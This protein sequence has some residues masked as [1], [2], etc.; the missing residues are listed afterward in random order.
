MLDGGYVYMEGVKVH[1]FYHNINGSQVTGQSPFE[2]WLNEAVTVHIQRQYENRLFG[3][4]YM[5]LEKVNYAF[6]PGR[7]P[8]AEDRKPNSMAIEPVGFNT[9]HELISAMTYSK[10]PE[11]V[12]MVQLILGDQ[13]FDRALHNYH[14]KFAFSNAKTED[15]INCMAE[16]APKNIDLHRMA[17][18]WLKRTGYPTVTVKAIDFDEKKQEV[19]VRIKQSGFENQES[20]NRYPWIVPLDFSLVKGGKAVHEGLHV[21]TKEEDEIVVGKVTSAPEFVSVGRNWSFFGEVNNEAFTPQMLEAQAM[22]DPDTV[23]RYLAFQSMVDEEKAVIIQAMLSGNG[24]SLKP[25]KR[26]LE[27]YNSVLTDS[28][29]SP[30][31]KA[32][33]LRVSESIS[34]RPDLQHRYKELSDTKKILLKAVYDAYGDTVLQMYDALA[35]KTKPG[36]QIEGLADRSLKGQLLKVLARGLPKEE[37]LKRLKAQLNSPFMTDKLVAFLLLLEL[38]EPQKSVMAEVKKEW[39]QHPIGCEQYI[40]AISNSDSANS[41]TYIRELLKEGFFNMSLAG[42]ARTVARGWASN[43]KLSLLTDAGLDLTVELIG[44]IGKVNQMSAYALLSAFGDLEK[45]EGAALERLVEALKKAQKILDKKEQQSLYNQLD[46]MLQKY[47]TIE[48]AHAKLPV[49]S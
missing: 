20:H 23:N 15:W 24:G 37:L 28:N 18:G 49:S 16:L 30:M 45:F 11:F 19:R 12:R 9:T 2:I 4:D 42:H 47:R 14:S 44:T 34:S 38:P 29:M 13:N 40:F 26:Y 33:I 27:L 6:T 17:E 7:G 10:A 22:S 32:F 43:R 5:R 48:E 21:L 39:M 31:N 25:S 3:A 1:E 41:A 36:P 46:T 35:A 8:L